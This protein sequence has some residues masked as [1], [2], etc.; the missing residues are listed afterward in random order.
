M[1]TETPDDEPEAA[2]PRPVNLTAALQ[3]HRD[4]FAAMAQPMRLLSMGDF[5][6]PIRQAAA[7]RETIT[8]GA[9]K[10][11]S[12]MHRMHS[13]IA[14]MTESFHHMIRAQE[15]IRK[16]LTSRLLELPAIS[17]RA[18]ELTGIAGQLAR[19]PK[20]DLAIDARTWQAAI[21]KASRRKPDSFRV[22]YNIARDDIFANFQGD[23]FAAE[24]AE[25]AN[26][27]RKVS[28]FDEMPDT[29]KFVQIFQI[30]NDNRSRG[31]QEFALSVA[32]SLLANSLTGAN[33]G[34]WLL[35]I[36]LLIWINRLAAGMR[37]PQARKL[38]RTIAIDKKTNRI[39]GHACS[40]FGQPKSRSPRIGRLQAGGV[41]SITDRQKGWREV[42]FVDLEGQHQVGWVRSKYLRKV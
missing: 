24:R 28:G 3:A 35:F 37:V 29:A 26:E 10:H 13:Q 31:F 16:S 7:L 21:E 36:F 38:L 11:V 40:I 19:I 30:A 34:F 42:Y 27:L 2:S 6:E 41:V 1:S 22:A 4:A 39:V 20:L 33:A 14:E 9:L 25:L 23:E 18:V 5:L 12:D 8:S 15:Q 32:G 17:K